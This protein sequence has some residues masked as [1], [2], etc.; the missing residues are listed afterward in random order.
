MTRHETLG[1][2][3]FVQDI[4]V[5]RSLV[6]PALAGSQFNPGRSSEYVYERASPGFGGRSLTDVSVVTR[7]ETKLF[8]VTCK[9]Y[10]VS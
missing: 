6:V 5:P 2:K 4:V 8:I 3:T 9:R 1:G 7:L 10:T